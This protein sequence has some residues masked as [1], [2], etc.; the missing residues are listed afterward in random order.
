MEYR[1][2][3]AD[4]T[5]K[6]ALFGSELFWQAYHNESALDKKYIRAYM[7]RAFSTQQIRK[8]VED[9]SIDFLLLESKGKWAGYAKL[10]EGTLHESLVEKD[11]LEIE[12]IYLHKS[13]WGRGFGK[14][15]MDKCVEIAKERSKMA[16]WLGVWNKN[17]RAIRFYEKY[18][19][20]KRGTVTFDLASSL[21][22]D[23]VMELVIG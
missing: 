2:V 5:E 20:E 17:A 6:L 1:I 11:T 12:R 10:V 7:A 4:E 14:P 16:I 19:F 22:E 18:G 3:T 13:Y 21:Q 8:E 9:P 23:D 15:L